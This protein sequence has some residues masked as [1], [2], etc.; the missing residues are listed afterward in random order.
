MYDDLH[1]NLGAEK[2]DIFL[3]KACYRT[4]TTDEDD[5]TI[6]DQNLLMQQ[7]M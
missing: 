4:K 2:H 3:E 7:E 6:N 5:Q 1:L